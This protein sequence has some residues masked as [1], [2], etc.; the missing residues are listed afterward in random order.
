MQCTVTYAIGMHEYLPTISLR[1]KFLLDTY[2]PDIL[3]L[4]EQRCEDP[5]LSFK[6][7]RGPQAKQFGKHGLKRQ[8]DTAN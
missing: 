5:W 6:A 8:G 7:K 3:Y 2:Q 1:Y 4:H